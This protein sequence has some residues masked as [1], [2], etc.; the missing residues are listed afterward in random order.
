MCVCICVNQYIFI[1]IFIFVLI[2]E[3][4]RNVEISKVIDT[5][6][7]YFHSFLEINTVSIP[8]KTTYISYLKCINGKI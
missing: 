5:F 2:T 4:I 6:P 3:V 7:L 8:W 1:Y